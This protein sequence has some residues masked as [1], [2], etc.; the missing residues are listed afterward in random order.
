MTAPMSRSFPRRAAGFVAKLAVSLGL[1]YYL[2]TKIDLP[3]MRAQFAHTSAAWLLLGAPFFAGMVLISGWRWSRIT[4]STRP[5][6]ADTTQ[7][8]KVISSV[9]TMPGRM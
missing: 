9:T 8:P 2:C 4:A 6:T 7:A 5:S 3:R 1:L